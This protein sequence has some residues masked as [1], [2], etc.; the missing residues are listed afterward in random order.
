MDHGTIFENRMICQIQK[1]MD[2]GGWKNLFTEAVPIK[3][4]KIRYSPKI[5]S[6]LAK[7]ERHAH[8]INRIEWNS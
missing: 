1:L 3:S 4:Q 7:F 2:I 5:F 8:F 6:I